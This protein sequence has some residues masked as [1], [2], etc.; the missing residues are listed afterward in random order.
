MN[1]ILLHTVWNNEILL[2]ALVLGL[3][4]TKDAA[5]KFNISCIT[6]INV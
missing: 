3:S 4:T 5:H 2:L 1:K 6:F